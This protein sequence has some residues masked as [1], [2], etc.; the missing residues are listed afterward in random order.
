MTTTV[1]IMTMTV[2]L[3]NSL[4]AWVGC[5]GLTL[6]FNRIL[7]NSL[8]SMPANRLDGI[9]GLA[10]RKSVS[11]CDD[12]SAARVPRRGW[13]V[14]P[15]CYN[16]TVFPLAFSTTRFVLMRFV[17]LPSRQRLHLQLPR[18]SWES[19]RCNR[20]QVEPRPT[21]RRKCSNP[22]NLIPPTGE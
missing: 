17:W 22:C 7:L 4:M 9:A 14:V 1:T 3:V 5:S 10:R 11:V 19:V 8:V 18:R 2:V 21:V 16:R 13:R 6:T 15:A 20:Q 12:R